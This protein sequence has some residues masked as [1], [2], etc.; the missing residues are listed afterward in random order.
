[1]KVAEI[2]TKQRSH[3]FHSQ[4]P[5]TGITTTG[6]T[7]S[8][9]DIVHQELLTAVK[10]GDKDDLTRALAA[11]ADI[12]EV[13]ERGW[14]AAMWAA[15][16]HRLDI[17]KMLKRAGASLAIRD[18]LNH[19]ARDLALYALYQRSLNTEV[20]AEIR[21]FIKQ[22]DG[23]RTQQEEL[24]KQA[25]QLAGKLKKLLKGQIQPVNVIAH[26]DWRI[27]G[28]YDKMRCVGWVFAGGFDLWIQNF[29]SDPIRLYC[30]LEHRDNLHPAHD[31]GLV[32]IIKQVTPSC[33]IYTENSNEALQIAAQRFARD[34]HNFHTLANLDLQRYESLVVSPRQ[35]R[36]WNSSED[37]DLIKQRLGLLSTLFERNSR[38]VPRP[39]I[40][41]V[42]RMQFE[43]RTKRRNR[44]A[45]PHVIGGQ[46]PHVVTCPT[47]QRAIHPVARLDCH[48]RIFQILSWP[49]PTLDV[50]FCANCSL[51]AGPTWV[52]HRTAIPR[53]LQ[54]EDVADMGRNAEPMA[55]ASFSIVPLKRKVGQQS[56]FGG[57]PTWIH[58]D[59]VPD[60]CRCQK[61]MQFV[62]QFV[63]NHTLS[64]ADES[65]LY[66]FACSDCTVSACVM[67]AH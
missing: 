11:G 26:R 36:L 7:R 6:D 30:N 3:A 52:D 2:V 20:T 9:P 25:H 54:Q 66:V 41:P 24:A 67:Q 38:P 59:E 1:M 65:I 27:D 47:C 10:A 35:L 60:C 21:K 32:P 55:E 61:A 48:D 46:L 12:D 23:Y 14:T 17:L 34:E 13:D 37:L 45:Y 22:D 28:Q 4:Q 19:D 63:S 29:H 5:E 31:R 18:G 39:I 56:T 44:V 57:A 51:F 40:F 15:Y 53:I 64:F 49:H 33:T 50:L 43:R 58:S 62:A 16:T 8:M 42:H